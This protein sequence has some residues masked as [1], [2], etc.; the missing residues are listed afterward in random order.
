MSFCRLENKKRRQ[1]R[2]KDT[3]KNVIRDV[4]RRRVVFLGNFARHR[5]TLLVSRELESRFCMT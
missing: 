2:E 5:G 1:E 4:C 3:K